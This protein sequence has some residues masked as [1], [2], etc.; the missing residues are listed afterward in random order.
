VT[1]AGKW[2]AILTAGLLVIAGRSLVRSSSVNTSNVVG[3]TIFPS[4]Q[5]PLM[6][7]VSGRTL[8]GQELRLAADHGHV[9]VLNSWGSWCTVCQQ[10]AP[11]LAV[12]AQQLK[13]S[14][15]QFVGVDV[16]DNTASAK[17]YMQYYGVAYPSLNDPGDLIAAEFN[18]LIP[19]SALPSTLVISLGGKIA[20]RVIGAASVEDLR[21]LIKAAALPRP[22]RRRRIAPSPQPPLGTSRLGRR[23]P[24]ALWLPSGRC[25]GWGRW[26]DGGP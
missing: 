6:P 23:W 22:P 15:V 10:E 7:A 4:G 20:G 26:A 13:P 19:I 21:L 12:A 8:T 18:Q 9:I 1:A 16:E 14:S 11:A 24:P 17:A 2:A 3:T 5:R 25:A